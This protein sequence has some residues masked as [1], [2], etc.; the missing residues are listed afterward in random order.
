M[1]IHTYT[2]IYIHIHTYTY[3]YIHIHTYTYIYIHTLHYTTLHYITYAQS[4]N[5]GL[6]S[7]EPF[8]KTHWSPTEVC[9]LE[10]LLSV[11]A[12]IWIWHVL[13]IH[14]I[15]RARHHRDPL[16]EKRERTLPEAVVYSCYQSQNLF[17]VCRTGVCPP[18]LASWLTTV[19]SHEVPAAV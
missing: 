8:L 19:G 10:I 1:H 11:I 3:I 15:L 13:R 9:V 17:S 18:L 12:R 16:L 14:Q 4:Y 2:Y 7:D 5:R 6:A